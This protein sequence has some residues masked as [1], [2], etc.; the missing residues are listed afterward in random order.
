MP[1]FHFFHPMEVRYGDLDP[2]GHVNNASFL[3]YFEQARIYYFVELGLI[4]KR[5]SAFEVGIILA[6]AQVT[7]LAPVLFGMDLDIQVGV[8]R[9]GNKSMTMDYLMLDNATGRELAKGS[10]V[11]VTFDYQ[12]Q[13]S[14][15]VPDEW[16]EK[17]SAFENLSG[18]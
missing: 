15:P 7:Y 1:D 5:S 11:L 2:Q 3:T 4:K 10:T 17:I 13:Q 6:D 8:T 18:K 12:K 9:L 14:T 16:R